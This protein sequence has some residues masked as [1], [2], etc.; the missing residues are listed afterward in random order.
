VTD[1]DS[2]TGEQSASASRNFCAQTPPPPTCTGQP[3]SVTADAATADEGTNTVPNT[4]TGKVGSFSDPCALPGADYSAAVT[5]TKV[6]PNSQTFTET[7]ANG[8]LVP[9][10]SGGYDIY[11]VQG[12]KIFTV[13][14][15]CE[16][17]TTHIVVTD[18]VDA[19]QGTADG[20]LTINED[21]VGGA[22]AVSATVTKSFT[23]T[24]ATFKLESGQSITGY[25]ATIDWGDGSAAGAGSIQSD[26]HG[27]YL[28]RGSHTYANPGS[29]TF[30]V[31]LKSGGSTA[32]AYTGTATVNPLT[33]PYS[34]KGTLTYLSSGHSTPGAF[35]L[36]LNYTDSQHI[37]GSFTFNETSKVSS[38]FSSKTTTIPL[39]S[40]SFNSVV[41]SGTTAYILGTATRGGSSGYT[42]LL[43][44]V[45]SGSVGRIG[46]QVWAPGAIP[47]KDMTFSP[48][49]VIG[50]ISIPSS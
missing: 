22:A 2:T 4:F 15:Q 20:T 39:A 17:F 34:G 26:G 31:T 7:V 13:A 41:Q 1:L 36:M 35:N 40:T 6:C 18:S 30:T 25:T 44:L 28:V 46:L 32:D 48:T 42:Y 8:G 33:H 49:N 5:I 11:V 12:Y 21:E 14:E 9:N 29:K 43:T 19:R 27:G 23:G 10:G 47:V 24:A 50:S 38:G 16:T 45:K 3:I 37:S